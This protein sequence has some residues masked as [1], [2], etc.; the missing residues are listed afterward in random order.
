MEVRSARSW[1]PDIEVAVADSVDTLRHPP[2]TPG[3]SLFR[4][5]FV[6]QYKSPLQLLFPEPVAGLRRLWVGRELRV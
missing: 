3:L 4:V 5:W 1:D 2:S 6:R